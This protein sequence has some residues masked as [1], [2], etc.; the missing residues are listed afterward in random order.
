MGA[1]EL[2][3]ELDFPAEQLS[4]E[5]VFVVEGF[6]GADLDEGGRGAGIGGLLEVADAGREEAL[7]VAAGAAEA[8]LGVGGFADE[9]LLV[10][11]GGLVIGGEFGEKGVVGGRVLRGKEDA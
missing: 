4:E 9:A 1:L 10:E 6:V 8:P 5:G 2:A 7:L 11:V 3:L